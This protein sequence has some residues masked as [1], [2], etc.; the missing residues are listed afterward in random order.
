MGSCTYR[1]AS[2]VCMCMNNQYQASSAALGWPRE[3]G[4]AISMHDLRNCT[5]KITPGW[6]LLFQV[7][8]LLR[9]HIYSFVV[10]LVSSPDPTLSQGVMVWWTTGS[11]PC[12][13]WT[14]AWHRF[15]I[16]WQL[17]HNYL[18]CESAPPEEKQSGGQSWISWAYSQKVVRTNEIARSVI[19]SLQQ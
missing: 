3:M 6:L 2:Y 15:A 5:F 14:S 19:I 7:S 1:V 17:R 9:I 4:T 12:R 10:S 18:F 8:I 16:A 13:K 11:Q